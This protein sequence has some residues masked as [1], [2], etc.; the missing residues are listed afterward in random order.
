MT[1]QELI[2]MLNTMP[3]LGATVLAFDADSRAMEPVS[4]AVYDR[5]RIELQTDD[6]A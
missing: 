6:P 3:D 4:G 1:A 2:D 5:D